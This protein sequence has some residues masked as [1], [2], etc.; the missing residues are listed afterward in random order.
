MTLHPAP[1]RFVLLLCTA[2]ILSMAGT[3][4]FPALLPFFQ[5]EWEL[6]N[7]AAGWIN[8]VFF[9]GYAL[10]SPVLVGL[11]DRMDP[12]KIYIPSAIL[13]FVSMALFGFAASGTWSA[14]ALR[15]LAGIS[16]AGTYMP[17]LKALSDHVSGPRQSR[18][19]VFYTAS[20]GIGTAA[21]VFLAG[22][23]HLSVGWQ[24]GAAL[25]ALGPLLACAIFAFAVP[26]GKTP[27][28]QAKTALP[29]KDIG[30]VVRNRAVLGYI[31]GYGAHCWELFGF[32]SWLVAFLTFCLSLP[33]TTSVPLSSQ[34][35]AMLILL[36]G[37][38]ATIFGNEGAM[39]WKRNRLIT[40]FMFGAGLIGCVI[41]FAAG[42]HPLAAVGFALIYGMAIMMDSGALTSGLVAE[43]DAA[44]R[45][46]TLAVYSFVGFTMAFLAP[47]C[48]GAVLD[49]AGHGVSGWGLAFSTM[50]IF[51]M[52][53]AVCLK[54][55]FFNRS[56]E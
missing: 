39:K 8:G 27:A 7:T 17:G 2:E 12:R 5:E 3:M 1:S 28:P 18:H 32:R 40:I 43:A 30:L 51:C 21:S 54:L 45:G 46:M 47:L 34:N 31:I 9:A 24:V 38:P 15:L 52:A 10:A 56:R 16:L 37:V 23:F 35:I 55:F 48:F 36:M 33:P 4:Y 11:T 26:I 50:G 42:L 25:T 53:A 6:S 20:Y 44:R 14:A 49:V 19:I 41:G 22:F 13:G 29:L